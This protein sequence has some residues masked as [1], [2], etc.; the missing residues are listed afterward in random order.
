MQHESHK[1]WISIIRDAV[2]AWRKANGYSRETA[3][4]RI[5]EAHEANGFNI[6]SGIIF[7]PNT[8]DAFE[9]MKV[10]A[11]RV[12]RWLDEVTKD[13]NLLPANFI[14]SILAALPDDY[15]LLALQRMLTP[16]GVSAHSF[17]D[18]KTTETPL[19]LLQ[20]ILVESGE[21]TSALVELV[22]GI[23]EGELLDAHQQLN[24]AI[25]AF[26]NARNTV[27]LMM[28]GQI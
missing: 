15:R 7:D 5:V 16:L 1:T 20:K 4:Q 24:E 18:A 22:D 28:R 13:R 21:A 8:R 23:E 17:C 26:T 2:E 14:P 9:R 12:F 3:A 25:A 6:S 11:D 27:E 10:N 19:T